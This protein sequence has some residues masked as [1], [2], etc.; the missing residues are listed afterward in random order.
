MRLKLELEWGEE[1][2]E[3]EAREKRFGEPE[4]QRTRSSGGYVGDDSPWHA[5]GDSFV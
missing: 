1:R 3:A 4:T 5:A 2:D